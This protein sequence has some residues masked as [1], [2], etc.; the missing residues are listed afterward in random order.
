MK[1]IEETINNCYSNCTGKDDDCD[2]YRE[3]K[4]Y[5]K[6][7]VCVQFKTIQSD[8]EKLHKGKTNITYETILNNLDNTVND[9]QFYIDKQG[10][11]MNVPLMYK[12][13]KQQFK[14]KFKNNII[15]KEQEEYCMTNIYDS[16]DAK[17]NVMNINKNIIKPEW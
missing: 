9:I 7:E 16:I 17:I 12:A 6:F 4:P 5:L 1:S 2:M 14:N 8:I 15:L 10:L 13:F 11:N 3:M